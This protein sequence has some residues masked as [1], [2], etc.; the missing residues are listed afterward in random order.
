MDILIFSGVVIALTQ[1]AKIAFG[2][3]KRYIP[4]VA[5]LIGAGLFTLAI[6]GGA[7]DFSYQSVIEALVSVLTAL[8]IYSGVKTTLN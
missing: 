8:G 2:V 4:L 1:V 5:L 7:V 6:Y 3:V